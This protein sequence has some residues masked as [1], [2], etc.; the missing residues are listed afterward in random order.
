MKLATSLMMVACPRCGLVVFPDGARGALFRTMPCAS[1][2]EF[3]EEARLRDLVGRLMASARSVP[4]GYYKFRRSVGLPLLPMRIDSCPYSR[5]CRRIYQPRRPPRHRMRHKSRMCRSRVFGNVNSPGGDAAAGPGSRL[6]PDALFVQGQARRRILLDNTQPGRG[7]GNGRLEITAEL[8]KRHA[9]MTSRW[10]S[11]HL[12][13]LVGCCMTLMLSSKV[14][15][16]WGRGVRGG[17]QLGRKGRSQGAGALLRGVVGAAPN[18]TSS[19]GAS[20]AP[21]RHRAHGM[22]ASGV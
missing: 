6:G 16:F 3:G 14:T 12:P 7:R 5:H 4:P 8:S 1:W 13:R 17:G 15:G 11:R 22:D 18:R 10:R 21:L 9:I 2:S 19:S 20:R